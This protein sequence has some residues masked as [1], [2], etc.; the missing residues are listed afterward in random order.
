MTDPAT[1]AEARH[2]AFLGYLTNLLPLPA[3]NQNY[4]SDSAVSSYGLDANNAA[5]IRYYDILGQTENDTMRNHP[6]PDMNAL[7]RLSSALAT[8]FDGYAR[9]QQSETVQVRQQLVQLPTAPIGCRRQLQ[10]F[11]VSMDLDFRLK[12]RIYNNYCL[13]WI[14]LL[15]PYAKAF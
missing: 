14:P 12:F 15:A 3:L 11:N 8:R 2:Y 13:V 9:S 1:S 5:W 4:P 7:A 10:P 6:P